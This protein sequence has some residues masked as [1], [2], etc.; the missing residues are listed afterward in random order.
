M[1]SRSGGACG[2][3]ML[4]MAGRAVTSGFAALRRYVTA[5]SLLKAV[6]NRLVSLSEGLSNC[7][8]TVQPWWE[9]VF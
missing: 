9:F 5:N 6:S 3:G 7:E 1:T 8:P 2:V 4:R